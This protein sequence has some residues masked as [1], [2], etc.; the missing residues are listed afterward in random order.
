M[1]HSD[2]GDWLLR[3]IESTRPDGLTVWY[4]GCNGFFVKASDGTTIAIDPYMGGGNPPRTVRMIPVPFDPTDVTQCDGILA[5]HEHSDH[6][7]GP[8]QGPILGATDAR[9]YGPDDS[10]AVC[11]DN[12]WAETYDLP[13][14]T[15]VTV[16]ETDSF[17]IGDVT[18]HVRAANDPDATHPV[19]YV[20]EHAGHT[21]FHAGDARPSEAFET[22]GTEFDLDLGAIA[23]GS[24][25]YIPDKNTNEPQRTKW[26]ND[27]NE[28][29]RA[30]EQLKLDRLLPTHWDMWRGLRADPT[31]LFDHKQSLRYPKHIDIARIGDSV[32]IL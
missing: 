24:I 27:E 14:E 9:F 28:I 20:I 12:G 25:G 15:F 6:V 31:A 26:Y 11:T 2:W 30:A 7:D 13:A 5:T 22:V 8:S 10:V 18:V 16:A 19:S 21:F 32:R 3:E 4:L 23:F 29:L 1:T 17:E